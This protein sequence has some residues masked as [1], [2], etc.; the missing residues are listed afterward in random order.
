MLRISERISE[1][2][3]IAQEKS[4]VLKENTRT[5]AKNRQR[6]QY[7]TIPFQKR[8]LR[9]QGYHILPGSTTCSVQNGDSE[10][11]DLRCNISPRGT[12]FYGLEAANTY[13]PQIEAPLMELLKVHYLKNNLIIEQEF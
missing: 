5:F 6:I 13:F 1:R 4:E 8:K 3:Q 11:R 7:N 9:K 2:Q 12:E 10:A